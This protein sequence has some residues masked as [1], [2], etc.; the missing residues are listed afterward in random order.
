MVETPQKIAKIDNNVYL[1]SCFAVDP[2]ILQE[3]N[4]KYVFHIGF[5][6]VEPILKHPYVAKNV[7]HEHFDVSDDVQSA[8]KMMEIG[9]YICNAIKHIDTSNNILVCC[10]AGKSRSA[11]VIVRYLHNKYTNLSYDEIIA[12]INKL[13]DIGINKGFESELK[14]M[15]I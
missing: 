5:E 14:K 6:I 13:R 8:P 1:G 15:F 2:N 3:Y 9:K 10:V 12:Y 11:S 7:K 4:I